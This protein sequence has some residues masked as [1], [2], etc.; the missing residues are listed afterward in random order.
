MLCIGGQT[1]WWTDPL[2]DRSLASLCDV[3][4]GRSQWTM[5]TTACGIMMTTRLSSSPTLA[6]PHPPP[7][8]TWLRPLSA[9]R[10]D[11][12]CLG[13][14]TAR[15]DDTYGIRC[16]FQRAARHAATSHPIVAAAAAEGTK[17]P[18]PAAPEVF[19]CIGWEEKKRF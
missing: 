2:V 1:P 6:D 16:L 19:E 5:A 8:P 18:S 3:T 11:G 14:N 17:S 13:G 7:P 9:V 15:S 4:K 12:R 10:W